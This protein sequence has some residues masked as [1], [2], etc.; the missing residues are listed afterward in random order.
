MTKEFKEFQER[1]KGYR[2]RSEL[3][4]DGDE[5]RKSL[6]AVEK[7]WVSA[8]KAVSLTESEQVRAALEATQRSSDVLA[9]N[10]LFADTSKVSPDT[11]LASV[12]KFQALEQI[13]SAFSPTAAAALE[14]AVAASVKLPGEE[15]AKTE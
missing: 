7:A 11:I 1:L 6:D 9:Y 15:T 2:E 5:L 10:I 12:V 13:R 3:Y 4:A 14:E 8:A